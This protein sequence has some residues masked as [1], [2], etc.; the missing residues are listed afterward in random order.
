M[1]QVKGSRPLVVWAHLLC[2]LSELNYCVSCL[3]SPTVWV[4]LSSPTVWVVWAYLL[5]E[6]SE[7]TY[8]VSLSWESTKEETKY[9]I[10]PETKYC[11]L[12]CLLDTCTLYLALSIHTPSIIDGGV[13]TYGCSA[14]P[15]AEA[16]SC[17]DSLGVCSFPYS[18]C[19]PRVRWL[20]SL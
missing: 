6:L 15:R 2:E 3:S 5:C 8:C 13:E 16:H 14:G 9:C 4:V 19:P 1:N 7:L 10:L 20:C 12:L 18:C 11:I 17:A